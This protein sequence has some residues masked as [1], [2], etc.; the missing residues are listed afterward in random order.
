ML[1]AGRRLSQYEKAEDEAMEAA[2]LTADVQREG[3]N[4]AAYMGRQLL[5]EVMQQAEKVIQQ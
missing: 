2:I 1:A 4:D 3:L 5:A